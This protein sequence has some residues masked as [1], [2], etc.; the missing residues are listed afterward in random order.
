MFYVYLLA[1]VPYGTLYVGV[2]DDVVK[3]VF[4]HKGKAVS[5]FTTRCGVNTLVWLEAH[6]TIEVAIRREKQIKE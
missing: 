2:T 5:D 4:E 1:I 6:D 3:R